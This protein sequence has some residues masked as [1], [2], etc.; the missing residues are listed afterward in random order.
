MRSIACWQSRFDMDLIIAM[1][2]IFDSCDV[3][4]LEI[5]AIVAASV[6]LY[7]V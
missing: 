5:P 6:V 7:R 2:R 3:F 1:H 4:E